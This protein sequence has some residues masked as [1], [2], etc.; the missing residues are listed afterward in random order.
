MTTEDVRGWFS[1]QTLAILAGVGVTLVGWGY[2]FNQVQS[3]TNRN[4]QAVNDLTVRISKNDSTTALLDTRVTGLEKVA[5]DAIMLRRELEA[6]V[7]NFRSDIAVIK[8]ILQRL[9]DKT[10][11]KEGRP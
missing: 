6:T 5:T 11:G 2:V 8:E 9:D 7:G 4:S 10:D 1:A 3:D